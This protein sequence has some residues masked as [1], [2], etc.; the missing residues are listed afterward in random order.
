M[1]ENYV[2]WFKFV[3]GYPKKDVIDCVGR[4]F[5]MKKIIELIKEKKYE[6]AIEML[7]NNLA[8]DFSVEKAIE[9]A[10]LEAQLQMND[11]FDLIAEGMKIDGENCIL[12]YLLGN[13]Y[14][15]Y[16]KNKALL[17]YKNAR[18]YY[19]KHGI[20]ETDVATVVFDKEPIKA[21][22][23]A[24]SEVSEC[25][26]VRDVSIVVISYNTREYT[27][28]CI[29]SIR[30]TCDS[31]VEIIVVDN[32][33]VDGSLEW[34]KNQKDILL[35]ENQENVGF[36]KGCNQGIMKAKA[37]ND[38][39]LL[40]SDTCLL[41]NSLFYLR[42]GLYDND[43]NAITGSVTNN[44]NNYQNIDDQKIEI[45]D[46]VDCFSKY[47]YPLNNPYEDKCYLESFAILIHRPALEKVGALDERF[48]LGNYEDNDLGYR[49]LKA[50][51]RNVLVHNSFIVHY[52]GKSFMKMASSY[53]DLLQKNKNLMID[54]WKFDFTYYQAIRYDLLDLF[55]ADSDD[56]INVLEIGCGL[57]ETLSRI[58][59]L[60][61]NAKIYGIE[62]V[63]DIA[64]L[65]HEKSNIICGDI[66]K[67]TLPYEKKYFDYIIMGD[68]IEHLADPEKVLEMLTEY[69][70][71]NGRFLASIPN[72]M[73]ASVIYDLLHGEFEYQDSG[74]LD[75]TH[76]RFFTYKSIIRM[77]RRTGYEIDNLFYKSL[78]LGRTD[79]YPE[80]FNQLLKIEGVCDREIFDVF[81]FLVKAKLKEK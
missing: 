11:V 36:P 43:K 7:S 75:R 74:I 9:G 14:L 81:Q 40:Q 28:K 44:A 80:F 62:I 25:T 22:E 58:K 39:F 4:L 77:F 19:H 73:N 70:A 24:I 1:Y 29:E 33:S 35:I 30:A 32:H 65:V 37:E 61:P 56:K 18:Y 23:D 54:K 60:Y 46:N 2:F 69:L 68:V 42:L 17:S 38:I 76:L 16:N 48:T 49:M 27:Q 21:I 41:P 57:G 26:D 53:V 50:G 52:G 47:N 72:L 63:E 45:D 3:T 10:F 8:D 15:E 78:T 6:N 55:D 79:N 31:D 51:Y 20:K 13:Y 66:T 34:L 67:M 64:N 12:Y 59:F 71:D 5:F